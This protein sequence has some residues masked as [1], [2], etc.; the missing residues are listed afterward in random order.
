VAKL[1]DVV[2]SALILAVAFVIFVST[3]VDDV[4]RL[5]P[6]PLLTRSLMAASTLTEDVE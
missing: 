5:P 1:F 6:T 4:A 2:L 3:L